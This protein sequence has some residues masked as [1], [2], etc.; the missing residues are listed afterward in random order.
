MLHRLSAT[1]PKD[2]PM[3][4]ARSSMPVSQ[5]LIHKISALPR[6]RIAEVEAFVDFIAQRDS[7]RALSRAAAAASAPALAAVWNNPEDDVYDSL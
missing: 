2:S 5:A 3:A 4:T 7:E 1:R 6:E